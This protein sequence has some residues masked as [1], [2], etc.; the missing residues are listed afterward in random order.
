[1]KNSKEGIWQVLELNWNGSEGRFHEKIK[2]SSFLYCP[3]Q[4][5]PVALSPEGKATGRQADHSPPSSAV[6]K[7]WIYTSAPPIRLQGV[8]LNYVKH[9]NILKKHSHLFRKSCL[10]SPTF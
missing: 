6:K 5:V 4:W 2:S 10:F 1:M 7:M 8:V 9:G 3:I